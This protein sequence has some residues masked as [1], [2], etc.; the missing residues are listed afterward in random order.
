MALDVALRGEQFFSGPLDLEVNVR[1]TAGVGDRFD[2]AE[3]IF[4]RGSGEKAA[5]ALEVGI[6]VLRVAAL[7]VQVSAVVV[8]LPDLDERITNR[9]ALG[10][11]NAAAQVC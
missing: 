1:R 4:A 8:A 6:A 2:G 5:E 3:I 10:I 7:G 9:V 11:E